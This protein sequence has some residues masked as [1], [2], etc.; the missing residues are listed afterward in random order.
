M[1]IYTYT[2]TYIYIYI[3]TAG[4][5][6]RHTVRHARRGVGA[7]GPAL[8]LIRCVIYIYIYI[9]IHTH[10]YIYIY[11]H[12]YIYIYTARRGGAGGAARCG[13]AT[14]GGDWPRARQRNESGPGCWAWPAHGWSQARRGFSARSVHDFG[15]SSWPGSYLRGGISFKLR[16]SGPEA[17]PVESPGRDT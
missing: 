3:H 12:I 7:A 9:H 15:P 11:I 2:Y 8:C 13:A 5:A 14:R 17:Q 16:G 10:I 6:A 4:C 1:N